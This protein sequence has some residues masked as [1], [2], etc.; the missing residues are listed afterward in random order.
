MAHYFLSNRDFAIIFLGKEKIIY[1]DPFFMQFYATKTLDN[2]FLE[3]PESTLSISHWPK[4]AIS[5]FTIT[6]PF[7]VGLKKVVKLNAQVGWWSQKVQLLYVISKAL[8]LFISS[9]HCFNLINGT[10]N[11]G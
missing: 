1:K 8:L 2:D 9:F 4:F 6:T 10:E 3:K 5:K 7:R 11:G